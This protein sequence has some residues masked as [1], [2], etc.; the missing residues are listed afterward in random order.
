MAATPDGAGYWLVTSAGTVYPYGDA[1]RLALRHHHHPIEGI[2]ASPA[3]G[4]WLYTAEGNVYRT[5][6]A[7]E[8]GSPAAQHAHTSTIV[9]MAPSADGRGYWLVTS[10]GTIYAYGDAAPRP[11]PHSHPIE[12]IVG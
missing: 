11:A 12:G 3:G 8:Y 2:V 4:Y 1:A 10:A 5:R 9:G 6:G 7:Q